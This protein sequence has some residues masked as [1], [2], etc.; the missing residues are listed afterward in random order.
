MIEPSHTELI[1]SPQLSAASRLR[2]LRLQLG[3]SRKKF[4]Q[5]TGISSNTLQA[6]ELG[7][8][9]VT[10]KGALKLS[11]ALEQMG[12]V[13]SVDWLL[14]GTGIPPRSPHTSQTQQSFDEDARILKEVAYF[15]ANNDASIVIIVMDDS[16]APF[17]KAGDYVAGYQC[18]ADKADLLLGENCI[19]T[20]Y[21]GSI[22]IRR[23]NKDINGCYNLYSLNPDTQAENAYVM[24]CKI[25]RIA[26]IVW[27]RTFDLGSIES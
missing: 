11:L 26:Q 21:S 15:E 25:Q 9:H 4:Q 12:V 10:E 16:M 22:L 20:L 2:G 5:A 27:H 3:L 24:D 8:N 17:Y 7:K 18:S 19:V 1:S 14:H 6:W 13:C 23:L